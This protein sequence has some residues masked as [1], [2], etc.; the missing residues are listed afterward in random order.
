M[1]RREITIKDIERVMPYSRGTTE[2]FL[3]GL[4]SAK[5]PVWTEKTSPCR[6]ACPVGN[7]IAR[8]F[9]FA[10]KGLIDEALRTY[11]QDNPLPGVCGRV[12]YHPCEASCNRK[13][14][15]EAINIRG[16][17]RFLADHGSVDEAAE[18]PAAA[19]AEKVAV[20]GSGPAGLAAAY[21]LARLGYR[22]S[23]F[24]ALAE[25]GGM[26][27][28]AI[29]GY[30]LPRDVLDKEIGHIRRLG[31][32]IRTGVRVG[33]DVSLVDIRK[34]YRAV[35]AAVGA[36][37]GLPLS[38]EGEDLPGVVEGIDFLKKVAAGEK[39]EPGDRVVVVG[40]GNTAVDCGRAARRL[41]AREV[42]I[43][44]R[45]SPS[46][47]PALREDVDAA[48]AEGVEIMFLAAP[49]RLLARDGRVSEMEA[50]RME[51]GETDATGRASPRPVAG[52]EFVLPADTVI[53]A[54]GQRPD[55]D[56]LREGGIR[57][58]ERGVIEVSPGTCATATGG[59]FAGGDAAGKRAFVADAIASGK[60]AAVA[61]A[62]YLE[63]KDAREHV[64]RHRIGSGP[65]LSFL[66]FASSG[67]DGVDLGTVATYDRL[68]TTCIPYAPRRGSPALLEPAD[69][70]KGFA[71]V[72]GCMEPAGMRAEVDRCF[73]C[74]TCIQCDL[75]FL[76]C[77]DMSIRKAGS[78]GYAVATDY[79]KGCGMCAA[80]CPRNALEIG[81]GR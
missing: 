12:C 60:A 30:R 43:V 62:C 54:V 75:C 10:S 19:R 46:E 72:T 66:H 63:G 4:W 35:F 74:G 44:Y 58:D 38:V 5:K 29:P 25:P 20:I 27:R 65:S 41:G 48:V 6:Q 78:G 31:V 69:A 51:L 40:G 24:E 2:I 57:T 22:V 15:D 71:E 1:E 13:E 70:V 36:H 17:E 33:E 56:F 55:T 45:R 53:A 81:G 3:T 28:Y 37:A 80:T 21:Y 79:C 42:T 77:P 68:N 11:R 7:D 14:M 34:E 16:F 18:A 59:V 26:L 76:L 50:I 32:E 39:V 9:A 64:E 67:R 8:A 47:M 73:K 52:S 23:I 49:R 61:I